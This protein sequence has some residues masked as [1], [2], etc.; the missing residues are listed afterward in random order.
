MS[1]D[2]LKAC[3]DRKIVCIILPANLSA[4]FQLLDVDFFNHVKLAYHAQVDNFQMGSGSVSISKGFFYCWHQCAWAKAANSR[5]IHKAWAKARLYPP[6][7]V[8]SG[9]LEAIL[10]NPITLP[11]PKTPRCNHTL[12]TLDLRLWH[13][14]IGPG[15]SAKKVRKGLE[16]ALAAKVVMERDLER[17]DAAAA[18]D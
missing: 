18:Q 4:V 15:Q 12:H 6:R 5:H 8:A 2:I 7:E 1:V 13:S 16:E 17:H 14:E 10:P 11:V 3:W 9:L